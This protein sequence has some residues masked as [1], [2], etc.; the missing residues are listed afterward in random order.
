MNRPTTAPT[1]FALGCVLYEMVAGKRAFKR[2][3][4]AETMTAILREEPP[5]FAET[6]AQVPPDLA[7][8]ISHCL[9]KNP[10]RRF[11]AAADVAFALGSGSEITTS[12][13]VPGETPRIRTWAMPLLAIAG[14]LLVALA[15]IFGP[16]ILERL[17]GHFEQAPIRSI[18][19][20][21]LENLTGD[22]EQQYSSTD[23]MR[24]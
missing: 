22:P 10:D 15:M 17:G 23:C 2:D 12:P 21:P 9:E 3:T 11:Q 24:S 4:N 8:T 16:G 18:A 13:A 1:F 6:G 5:S 7:K 19:I 20:L 14:I